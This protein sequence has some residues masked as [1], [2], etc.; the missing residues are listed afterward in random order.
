MT[1]RTRVTTAV[2]AELLLPDAGR[3]PVRSTWHY[4]CG[5]PFA[6][7]VDFDVEPGV[8]EHWTFA[9]DLL[10]EGLDVP[11]GYGDVLIEPEAGHQHVLLI[12]RGVDGSTALLRAGC[13]GLEEFLRRS[14]AGVPAGCEQYRADLDDWIRAALEGDGPDGDGLEGD[15]LDSG[16]QRPSG[17]R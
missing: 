7:H 5:D 2:P 9:R 16:G 11:A 15:G 4:D 14:F 13:A 6:V 3:M 17:H 12:L 1:T 10:A 8:S